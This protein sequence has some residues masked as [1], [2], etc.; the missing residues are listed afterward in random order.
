MVSGG[1]REF[2]S[3]TRKEALRDADGQVFDVAVVGAGINGSATANLLATSGIR[4][5][6]LDRRD[7]AYG[8]SSRSSKMIHAASG[9]SSRGGA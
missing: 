8:T 2:S 3:S 6:L 5:V 1:A 4:T 7:F 9:T